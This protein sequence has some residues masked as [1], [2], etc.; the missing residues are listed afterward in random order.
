MYMP[1]SPVHRLASVTRVTIQV[2]ASTQK[3]KCAILQAQFG[4]LYAASTAENV[5]YTMEADNSSQGRCIRRHAC[6]HCDGHKHPAPKV[7]VPSLWRQLVAASASAVHT[8]G[9]QPC[10]KK[11]SFKQANQKQQLCENNKRLPPRLRNWPR[12]LLYTL[13]GGEPAC[14]SSSI[15]NHLIRRLHRPHTG[16][17]TEQRQQ[18]QDAGECESQSQPQQAATVQHT[19]ATFLTLGQ[20]QQHRQ[21][22]QK[23]TVKQSQNA[24]Q[25][26]R[27]S[28]SSKRPVVKRQ[29][30]CLRECVTQIPAAATNKLITVPH[31]ER[32]AENIRAAAHICLALVARGEAAVAVVVKALQ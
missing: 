3:K 32:E 8:T 20:S 7:N 16:M 23:M 9:G 2:G 27:M 25:I 29:P 24:W 13:L 28:A 21:G 19:T 31:L 15:L 12:M 10:I 17:A 4:Q 11:D 1:S 14:S 6:Q 30:V 18:G 22:Q 26:C 5:V